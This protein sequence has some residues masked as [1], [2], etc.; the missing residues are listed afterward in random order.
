MPYNKDWRNAGEGALNMA[1]RKNSSWRDD[2]L[3][4]IEKDNWAE[5]WKDDPARCHVYSHLKEKMGKGSK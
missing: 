3:V 5:A 4:G 1:T 2:F